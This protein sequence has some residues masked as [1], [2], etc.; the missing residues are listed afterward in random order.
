MK[1]NKT[2]RESLQELLIGDSLGG[3]RRMAM[4]RGFTF[5]EADKMLKTTIDDL[6]T[7]FK[8]EMLKVI[9]RNEEDHKL[10][11][12]IYKNYTAVARNQLR[13]SQRQALQKLIENIR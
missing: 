9:G 2:L 10:G 6:L 5:S 8:D 3:Y 7:L 13:Q 11:G 4:A 1:T 12:F